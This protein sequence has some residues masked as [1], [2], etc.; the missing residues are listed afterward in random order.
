MSY[1]VA[2]DA[3]DFLATNAKTQNGSPSI[4]FFGGEPL[5]LW[6]EIVVPLTLYIRAR[7]GGNYKLSMTSN[8][9]L[10][11]K[12]KL[13]FMRDQKIGLLFS[14][15][16]DKETQDYNRPCHNGSSSFHILKSK[17]PLILSYYPGMTFRATIIPE[18]CQHT[19]HN[20]MFAINAGYKS[21]FVVPNTL[22]DWD[23]QSK[24]ELSKQMRQY[25]DYIVETFRAGRKP[26]TFT[27]LDKM[28]RT[29]LMI[30]EALDSNIMRC[31]PNCLSTGKCGLGAKKFASIDFAG[32]V[33]GCQEVISSSGDDSIFHIGSIY[34]GVDDARRVKLMNAYAPELVIGDDCD[35]C[36]LSRVC[37]GGCVAH[38]YLK[39]GSLTTPNHMYCWWQRLMLRDATYISN[40]L[41]EE[42]NLLFQGYWSKYCCPE[43][44]GCNG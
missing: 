23:E 3:A 15:D 9:I 6:D 26:P 43:N 10:L 30:N 28:Y 2:Q 13:D 20:L 25:S 32:N 41:G 19:F 34:K 14:L 38:N 37:D 8:C 36:P 44:G 17:I 35:N 22:I 21:V 31:S 33:Y 16:G 5:L 29:I 27:T 18:T 1:Q 24:H 42:E 40:I 11:D 7:Y 4:N 39:S 12:A